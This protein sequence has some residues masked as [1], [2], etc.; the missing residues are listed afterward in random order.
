MMRGQHVQRIILFLCW[1][2]SNVDGAFIEVPSN[3]RC[4]GR[5]LGIE[6]LQRIFSLLFFVGVPVNFADFFQE[7]KRLFQ[8]N[9]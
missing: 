9:C 6:D 7:K 5:V 3:V 4:A 2:P 1:A 8:M